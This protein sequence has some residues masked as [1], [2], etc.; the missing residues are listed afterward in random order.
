MNKRLFT[1]TFVVVLCG[2]GMR[3]GVRGQGTDQ[4]T[5]ATAAA[6]TKGTE[7]K[8]KKE[9]AG[10][11]ANGSRGARAAAV[12]Q[13]VAELP[14]TRVITDKETW[15]KV[16]KDW[17]TEAGGRVPARGGAVALALTGEAPEIDFSKEMVV[18]GLGDGGTVGLEPLTVDEK[19]DLKVAVKML[20]GNGGSGGAGFAM[21][22]VSREG[23]KTVNG[24]GLGNDSRPA[25]SK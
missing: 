8:A 2:V 18:V 10:F 5:E 6:P 12:K 4:A 21:A 13:L 20:A 15:A 24:K 7:V 17:G 3:A 23:I 19:G 22:Q 14:A 1:C 11:L 25:A 16:W 9:W